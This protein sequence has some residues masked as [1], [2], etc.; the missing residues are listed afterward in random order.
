MERGTQGPDEDSEQPDWG[1]D[2]PMPQPAAVP[3]EAKLAPPPQPEEQVEPDPI[4]AETSGIVEPHS[5]GLFFQQT[6]LNMLEEQSF[7]SKEEIKSRIKESGRKFTDGTFNGITNLT[8]RGTGETHWIGEMADSPGNRIRKVLYLTRFKDNRT[9]M[10][11]LL[12]SDDEELTNIEAAGRTYEFSEEAWNNRP[13]KHDSFTI[14]ESSDTQESENGPV[15]IYIQDNGLLQNLKQIIIK[16]SHRKYYAHFVNTASIPSHWPNGHN[17]EEIFQN[18]SGIILFDTPIFLFK[19]NQESPFEVAVD[20]SAPTELVTGIFYNQVTKGDFLQGIYGLNK[21]V[22]GGGQTY[23]DLTRKLNKDLPIFLDH[24]RI[25]EHNSEERPVYEIIVDTLGVSESSKPIIIG[26]RTNRGYNIRAA[27]SHP[28]W[29]P[30][31]GFPSLPLEFQK[32]VKS[33]ENVLHYGV[34]GSGKSFT[35]RKTELLQNATMSRTIV[36]H[37]DYTYGDFVGQI[38]PVSTKNEGIDYAFV[39]GPFTEILNEA[40]NNP[41]GKYVLIIEEINRGNAPAIFGDVFQLLDRRN[42]KDENGPQGESEY[43]IQ[44]NSIA[45]YIYND[46]KIGIRIPPNLWI[47]GTMNTS[48]QNVFTLDTA[49]QRRWRMRLTENTFEGHKFRNHTILDTSVSWEKFCTTLN[50]VIIG[51]SSGRTSLEDKRM[52]TYFVS[53]KDLSLSDEDSKRNFPEKV[54]KYLWDDAFKFNQ[55]HVFDKPKFKTLEKVIRTFVEKE[56]NDR[57]SVFM[58]KLRES[59]GLGGTTAPKSD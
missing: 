24:A 1:E 54:L 10:G 14:L 58:P 22:G 25:R 12:L 53:E 37:P 46:E 49:F 26:P 28:A 15:E 2:L 13:R 47:L 7:V 27:P 45:N 50:D 16:T 51:G 40:I 36:F 38:M 44:H 4:H 5:A 35:I 20:V 21:P 11:F 29:T 52:G 6:L 17:L 8:S 56:G 23:F 31:N 9:R 30:V 57:F 41:G 19:N 48:D 59:L 39:A 32:D 34:P 55:E 18:T 33:G 3:Q 42:A 43:A